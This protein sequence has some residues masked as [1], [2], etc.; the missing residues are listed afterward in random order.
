[1][2]SAS[3]DL[4]HP[5]QLRSLLKDLREVRQAKIR[6]GLQSEGVMRGSYLQVNLSPL[7]CLRSV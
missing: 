3:D 1:M 5:G 7:L 4:S 2:N 6:I